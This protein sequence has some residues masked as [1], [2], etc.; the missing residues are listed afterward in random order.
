MPFVHCSQCDLM[1]RVLDDS[2]E[3]VRCASCGRKLYLDEENDQ[4]PRSRRGP[5]RKGSR[6]EGGSFLQRNLAWLVP[7][8]VLVPMAIIIILIVAFRTGPSFPGPAREPISPTSLKGLVGY[9]PFDEGR[10]GWAADQSGNGMTAVLNGA[11]WI[12]GVRGQAV[13][14]DGHSSYVDLGASPRLNFGAGEPVTIA[15]WLETS[16]DSGQV[17]AFRFAA[18]GAAVLGVD[19]LNG[20]R[21]Q[22]VVRANGPE[23]GE[24]RV[25]GKQVN[26]GRWH[27]F[28]LI[29]HPDGTAELYLDGDTQQRNR[30]GNSQGP[31]TTDLRGLGSERYH[32]ARRNQG[33]YFAGALDEFCVFNRALTPREI[34]SLAGR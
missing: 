26:D 9:W 21:V 12:K 29:R 11:T 17:F 1:V 27:H 3:F 15:G 23:L 6:S 24:A 20:G 7:V 30:S 13:L 2:R 25:Y 4:D 22:G 28:A 8:G 16:A 32:A 14:L 31:I 34:Q 10:G 5:V 19:L 18:H 33:D